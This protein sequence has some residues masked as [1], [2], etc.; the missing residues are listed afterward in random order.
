MLELHPLINNFELETFYFDCS[1]FGRI[2]HRVF[3]GD[4]PADVPP[5]R[6]RVCLWGDRALHPRVRLVVAGPS[7]GAQ[8]PT[9][10][11]DS[12]N[13]PIIKHLSSSPTRWPGFSRLWWPSDSASRHF[14]RREAI[15][16][17]ESPL[18]SLLCSL[19][20]K[21]LNLKTAFLS[22]SAW[23]IIL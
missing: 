18:P 19:K 3:Q 21:I 1:S 20:S 17:V 16:A 15:G 5:G 11:Q 9:G 7:K 23:L 2:R 14:T 6:Q 22:C 4:S 10:E 13:F 12:G 8:H